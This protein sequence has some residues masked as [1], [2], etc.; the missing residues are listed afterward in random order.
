MEKKT[1]T[2]ALVS[3]ILSIVGFF[4]FG[5]ILGI[6]SLVMGNNAM[7][8]INQETEKGY[9]LAKAAKIIGIIDIIGGLI[10][11]LLMCCS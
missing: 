3:F 2:K 9:G 11:I 1:N 7:Q 5:I 10:G 8:E 6:I 4:I